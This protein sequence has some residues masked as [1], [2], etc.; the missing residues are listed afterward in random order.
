MLRNWWIGVAAGVALGLGAV[1]GVQAV[2]D[3]ATAQGGFTVTP[4]Q[5]KINQRI[6]Q[7]AVRRSN[8]SL[9]LL[10]PIRREQKQPNKV[11]GWRTQDLRD[12]AV[13]AAKLDNGA[14][15]EPKLAAGVQGQ[16]HTVYRAAVFN[17]PGQDPALEPQSEGVTALARTPA[18]P[19]GGFDLTFVQALTQCTFTGSVATS[20][21]SALTP[22]FA[23]FVVWPTLLGT[24]QLRVFVLNATT[25]T[26]SD[27][28][29]TVTVFCS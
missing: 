7:A 22:V 2:T 1:V 11:L 19:A 27:A 17:T 16:L 28:P 12:S 14:V 9:Q 15:S 26:P 3:T 24:N 8:E 20:R 25:G 21:G 6:S 4:A 23:P 10:D 13:T 18:L 29:F 5:L